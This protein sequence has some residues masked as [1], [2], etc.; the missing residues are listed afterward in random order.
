MS[1]CRALVCFASMFLALQAV[2]AEALTGYIQAAPQP[3][4]SVYATV[5]VNLANGNIT[6]CPATSS[7]GTPYGGCKQVGIISVAGVTRPTQIQIGIQNP[8][9]A[10]ITNLINGQMMM[11]DL[12]L[13]SNFVPKGTL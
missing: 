6:V 11:C 5:T 8:S 10:T 9:V 12:S 1:S 13:D 2:T 7:S 4:A 3:N